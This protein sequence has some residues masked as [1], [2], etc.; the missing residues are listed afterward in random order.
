MPHYKLARPIA[1]TV[2]LISAV[3]LTWLVLTLATFPQ[4]TAQAAPTGGVVGTGTPASCTEAALNAR[5]AGGGTVTFNCGAT[6]YTIT[7]TSS[8]TITANTTIDG[9]GKITLSGSGTTRIFLVNPGIRLTLNNLNVAN[10]SSVA[11]GCIAVALGTLNA[12]QTT[13]HNCVGRPAGN[14]GAIYGF[15]AIIALT[16][17]SLLNNVVENSGGGL[18]LYGGQAT[19]NKVSV[20]NNTAN[21]T[22][23]GSG[24]GL[25]ITATAQ[26][27]INN[28]Q[29]SNNHI[30]YTGQGGGLYAF[31]STLKLYNTAVN[32]NRA[33]NA[34]DGG[35]L[36][37]EHGSVLLSGGA[38]NGN[39]GLYD[40]G[41]MAIQNAHADLNGV[42]LDGNDASSNGGGLYAFESTVNLT[43]V[44]ISRNTADSDGAGLHC[45]GCTG[46]LTRVTIDGNSATYRDGG[47][48]LVYLSS[49]AIRDSTIR[50]NTDRYGGGIYNSQ[51]TLTLDGVTLNNNTATLLG[52]GLYNEGIANLTNATLSANTSITG[53]AIYNEPYANQAFITLTNVTVK[54]NSAT[55]G[56]GLYNFNDPDAA[57]Y[58][59]NTILADSLGGGN[60]KGKNIASARYS[61]SSDSTCILSG[62]GNHTNLDPLLTYLANNGGW[63]KTHLPRTNSPAVN[64][65]V[66]NDCPSF[67][68]RGVAR[69]QGASCD[70]GAVERKSNDPPYPIAAYL[71]IVIR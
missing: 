32:N 47:G 70:I 15:G 45:Y 14:G 66:G 46:N 17:T 1:A 48:M 7:L 40:G 65:V 51:S 56:G 20:L 37:V 28:S 33:D 16:D 23:T 49:F 50:N 38:V 71:P 30:G 35:G 43:D 6:P 42:T 34:A 12:T 26:V 54:D 36:Y 18:Y 58:L 63:T 25:Y 24:G 21:Y 67:D 64:G 22:Y 19:L 10:G 9:G 4:H 11:G 3:L 29:I 8:K 44:V 69:P 68:Q 5:L 39:A 41:G 57:V 13:V 59:K 61:I 27:T 2:P 62:T 55:D 60:C 53:G 52:G 31:T